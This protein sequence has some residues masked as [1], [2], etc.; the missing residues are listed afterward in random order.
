MI[1]KFTRYVRYMCFRMLNRRDQKSK[2]KKEI[3]DRIWAY[4]I[5]PPR[6]KDDIWNGWKPKKV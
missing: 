6:L 4:Y 5:K 2:M 1:G 3:F